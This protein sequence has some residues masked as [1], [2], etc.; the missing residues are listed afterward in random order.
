MIF[1]YFLVQ[2]PD[3]EP[4]NLLPCKSFRICLALLLHRRL[5]L[6][7]GGELLDFLLAAGLFP[8]RS[9]GFYSWRIMVP[10]RSVS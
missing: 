9:S 5:L 6:L 7:C 8:P 2:E 4:R 3:L 10:D 1:P